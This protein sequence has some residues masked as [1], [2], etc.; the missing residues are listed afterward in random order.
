MI[1][2]HIRYDHYVVYDCGIITGEIGYGY[3]KRNK[4]RIVK[5]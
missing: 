4:K 1:Y 3:G 2:K 5:R